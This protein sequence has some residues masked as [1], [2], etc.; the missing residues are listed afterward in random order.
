MRTASR[1]DK[2]DPPLIIDPD[3][4][5]A[6]TITFQLLQSVSGW[7]QQVFEIGGAV[8]HREFSLSH[9]SEA[10]KIL[11]HLASKK[12]LRLLIPKPSNHDIQPIIALR[13]TYSVCAK[14]VLKLCKTDRINQNQ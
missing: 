1:P 2:A 7:R 9:L 13:F 12:L 11:H 14:F 5:L 3:T 8:E 10:G 4:V 6:G